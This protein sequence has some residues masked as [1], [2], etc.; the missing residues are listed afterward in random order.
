[1]IKTESQLF[2]TFGE[3]LKNQERNILLVDVLVELRKMRP[4]AYPNFTR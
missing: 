1:M 3:F 2:P 4:L